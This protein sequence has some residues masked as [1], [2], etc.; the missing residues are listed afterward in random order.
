MG[1]G[2]T[3]VME[4]ALYDELGPFFT[5][6]FES[7][8]FILKD[9]AKSRKLHKYLKWPGKIRTCTAIGTIQDHVAPQ[10]IWPLII[11]VIEAPSLKL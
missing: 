7:E 2:L 10:V 8:L 6:L 4:N 9:W 3:V 1:L 5:R 11:D